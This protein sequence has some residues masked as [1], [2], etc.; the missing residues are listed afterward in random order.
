K[1]GSRPGAARPKG[2]ALMRLEPGHA[3]GMGAGRRPKAARPAPLP[4]G[5]RGE[6][7]GAAPHW[8]R[9]QA[10]QRMLTLEGHHAVWPKTDCKRLT[11][12]T[13]SSRKRCMV[14]SIAPPPPFSVLLSYHFGPVTSSSTTPPPIET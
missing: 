2:L 12:E 3:K 5:E 9:P 14:K 13:K 1:A 8:A 11:A 4:R 6:S 7:R 10:A